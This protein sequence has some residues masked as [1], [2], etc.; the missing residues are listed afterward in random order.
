MTEE[1]PLGDS[2][3]LWKYASDGAIPFGL[4]PTKELAN[5]I[6][7]VIYGYSALEFHM[8]LNMACMSSKSS[9]ESFQEFYSA[10]SIHNKQNLSCLRATVLPPEFQIA[11]TRLWRW[12][13]GAADRRTQ[14]AHC[15]ISRKD[16]SV[17]GVQLV[18]GKALFVSLDKKRFIKTIR[19]FRTLQT[20]IHMLFVCLRLLEPDRCRERLAE[21]PLPRRTDNPEE[22]GPD[23]AALSPRAEGERIASLKRLG[24]D[25]I[26]FLEKSIYPRWTNY[27]LR[28][29]GKLVLWLTAP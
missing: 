17:L 8:Y 18:G 12:M 2:D 6:G 10:R 13:R 7:R 21:V 15:V 3:A 5:W 14:V 24:L 11:H 26:L 28:F 29:Q 27:P 19:Q 25:G 9:V 1:D 22:I 16:E 23:S 20:D 4:G